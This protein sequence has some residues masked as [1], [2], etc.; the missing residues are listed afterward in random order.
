MLTAVVQACI[1]CR[2]RKVRCDLGSVEN[3]S[4]PP[5]ARCRRESKECYFSAQ[6]RTLRPPGGSIGQ[7][8][9]L[10]RSAD[11]RLGQ[12]SE[13]AQQASEQTVGLLQ[14]VEVHGG[15]DAMKLLSEV[16]RKGYRESGPPPEDHTGTKV[17]ANLTESE[18][19]EDDIFAGLDMA[20][21]DDFSFT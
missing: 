11:S 5:C 21:Q 13:E 16:A 9:P 7:T 1:P 20:D 18:N 15:H 8:Q 6:R 12:S 4:D 14:S 17:T 19:A 10:R 2:Q 3:F